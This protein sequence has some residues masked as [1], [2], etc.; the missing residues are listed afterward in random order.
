[1]TQ[2]ETQQD[3]ERAACKLFGAKGFVATSMSEIAKIVGVTKASLY[4]FFGDKSELY[5]VVLAKALREVLGAVKGARENRSPEEA[6]EETIHQMITIGMS[7]Q[8]FAT[9][10]DVKSIQK[11]KKRIEEMDTVVNELKNELAQTLKHAGI[12]QEEVAVKVLMNA[13]H[14]YVKHCDDK[15]DNIDPHRYGTYLTDLLLKRI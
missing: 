5:L 9:M 1:M 3:I 8:V 14:G 4:Y 11:H 2:K 10:P 6:V 15:Q 7:N 13:V 12:S